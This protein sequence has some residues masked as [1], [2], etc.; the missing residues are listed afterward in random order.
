[1]MGTEEANVARQGG[2]LKRLAAAIRPAR[3]K[4]A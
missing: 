1:V 4:A 2:L 3:M